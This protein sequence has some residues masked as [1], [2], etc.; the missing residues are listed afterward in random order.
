MIQINIHELEYLFRRPIKDAIDLHSAAKHLMRELDGAAVLV[1]QGADGMTL[2]RPDE[3]PWHQAAAGPRPVFDV[4]GAGDTVVSLLACG[5]A[6]PRAVQI[7]NLAASIVVGKLGTAVVTIEE[8][9]TAI[10]AERTNA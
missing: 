3:D 1:T 4:T 6:L 2:F 8:L 7:A 5:G 10:Q 9:R